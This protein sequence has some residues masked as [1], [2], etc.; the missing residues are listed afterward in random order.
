MSSYMVLILKK[1]AGKKDIAAIRKKLEKLSGKGV[2]TKKYCGV[3]K[4][5]EDPLS[6]QKKM[7]DEWE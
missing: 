4:L 1:G 3:I 7:R 6:M 2:D 5:K